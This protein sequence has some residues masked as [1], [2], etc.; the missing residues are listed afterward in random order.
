[1][2]GAIPTVVAITAEEEDSPPTWGRTQDQ[3]AEETCLNIAETM[4]IDTAEIEYVFQKLHLAICVPHV[5]TFVPLLSQLQQHL[6]HHRIQKRV[7]GWYATESPQG[8]CGAYRNVDAYQLP[9]A[10][11]SPNC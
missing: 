2:L 11:S 10:S 5:K 4:P 3:T 9:G 7:G 8:V 1:M 6:P